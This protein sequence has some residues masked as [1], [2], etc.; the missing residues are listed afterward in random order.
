MKLG[1]IM[2]V[3]LSMLIVMGAINLS[4]HKDAESMSLGL[5]MENDYHHIQT[6]NVV[7]DA[8]NKKNVDRISYTNTNNHQ[9]NISSSDI[10][11]SCIGSG[12]NEYND[13]NLVKDNFK[14]NAK[15]AKTANGNKYDS[16]TVEKREKVYIYLYTEYVGDTFPSNEV[17]CNYSVK[18]DTY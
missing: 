4:L 9:I 5:A 6:N 12:K 14:I 1:R 10:K 8:S 3:F 11:I 2:G 7:M 13:V 15:F 17:I 16:L 18:I